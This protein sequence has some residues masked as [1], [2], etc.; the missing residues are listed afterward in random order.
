MHL[1]IVFF[2]QGISLYLSAW[3]LLT[4]SYKIEITTEFKKIAEFFTDVNAL[5]EIAGNVSGTRTKI[6]VDH[7]SK[8]P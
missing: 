6:F 2:F 8:I 5:A 1:T 7:S 3:E 4:K